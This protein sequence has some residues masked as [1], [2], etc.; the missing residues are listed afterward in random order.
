MNN[1]SASENTIRMDSR[2]TLI[3][4]LV[5]IAIISILAAMLLPALNKAKKKVNEASCASNLK[6]WGQFY[7][8]YN[9]DFDDYFPAC[10]IGPADNK[11]VQSWTY[12]FSDLGYI[13]TER[14]KWPGSGNIAL[15]FLNC[16]GNP[17]PDEGTYGTDYNPNPMLC[18]SAISWTTFNSYDGYKYR[19]NKAAPWTAKMILLMEHSGKQFMLTHWNF[20]DLST[21]PLRWRHD[22][23]RKVGSKQAPTGGSANVVFVNG[24]VASLRFKEYYNQYPAKFKPIYARPDRYK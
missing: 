21:S 1:R 4:L 18:A 23:I 20:N 22:P 14:K 5:V 13:K 12:L 9:A 8:M 19:W 6:S 2:F 24:A 16:P 11:L 15:R 10:K 17:V 3:E 7:A